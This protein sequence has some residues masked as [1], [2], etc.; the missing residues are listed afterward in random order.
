MPGLG[1]VRSAPD[2]RDNRYL[3]RAVAPPRAETQLRPYRHHATFYPPLDQGDTSWCCEEMAR[4]VALS[5]PQRHRSILQQPHGAGY[6]WMQRNDAWA[7]EEP[8]YYGTSPRAAAEWLRTVLGVVREY[9][10]I[11]TRAEA[12]AWLSDVGPLGVGFDW[13]DSFYHDPVMGNGGKLVIEP[14]ARVVGG[15]AFLI[16][17]YNLARQE[18]TMQQSWGAGTYRRGRAEIPFATFDALLE[19]YG[20][21]L[22]FIEAEI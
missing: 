14:G 11:R 21:V 22:G 2:E 15:H 3:A 19:S 12:L 4:G 1:R 7:G 5:S 20:E 18:F 13:Y 6:A 17:G 9:R 8:S 10:W 16:P